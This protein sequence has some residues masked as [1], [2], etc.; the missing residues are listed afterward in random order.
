MSFVAFAFSAAGAEVTC[1]ECGHSKPSF[2]APR[3][4]ALHDFFNHKF[5]TK[6]GAFLLS[7]GEQEITPLVSQK[8]QR[9]KL[10]L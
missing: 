4:T 8:Q 9:P 6:C 10:K 2:H 3:A 7:L 5:A 1:L